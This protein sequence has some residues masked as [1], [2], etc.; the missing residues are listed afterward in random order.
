MTRTQLA[1]AAALLAGGCG[2]GDAAPPEASRRSCRLFEGVSKTIPAGGV[3]ITLEVPTDWAEA[4]YDDGSCRFTPARGAGHVS[5][6]LPFCLEVPDRPCDQGLA[7]GTARRETSDT[8]V[9]GQ[10]MRRSELQV[11][12]PRTR[13]A[14]ACAAVVQGAAITPDLERQLLRLERICDSIAVVPG[15]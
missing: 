7:G 15:H 8:T 14:V 1:L 9:L 5:V 4:H 2:G 11:A 10:T 3:G 12:D 6:S 13:R